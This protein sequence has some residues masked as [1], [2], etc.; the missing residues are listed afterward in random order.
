M[1]EHTYPFA[2]RP[3]SHWAITEAWAI[4]DLLHPGVL[5]ENV[6]ALLAGAIAG[7]LERVVADARRGLY[8]GPDVPEPQP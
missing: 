3:G 1:S 7:T 5:S 6:R 8:D 2:Y 4:L